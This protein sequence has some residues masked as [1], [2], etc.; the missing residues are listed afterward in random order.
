MEKG[1]QSVANSNTKSRPQ[2]L[3]TDLEVV[4]EQPIDIDYPKLL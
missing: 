2:F 3:Q 1:L 4:P